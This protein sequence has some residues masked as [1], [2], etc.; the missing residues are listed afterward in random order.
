[1]NLLRLKIQRSGF[2]SIAV[3]EGQ[4][5]FPITNPGDIPDGMEDGIFSIDP[6]NRVAKFESRQ[7]DLSYVT[8][9][10]LK[11]RNDSAAPQ[12]ASINGT[13]VIH[14]LDGKVSAILSPDHVVVDAA[15]LQ[16]ETK[17]LIAALALE[18]YD[19]ADP[20]FSKVLRYILK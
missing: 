8:V 1:M 18:G 4:Q 2:G 3:G 9:R 11:N 19:L 12:K 14:L 5:T 7:A 17:T 6:V 10:G 15:A 16:A 13:T 20:R